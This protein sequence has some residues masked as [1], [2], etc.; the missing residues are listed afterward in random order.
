MSSSPTLTIR[1]PVPTS[2]AASVTIG[3][4][5]DPQSKVLQIAAVIARIA[6]STIATVAA[7]VFLPLPFAIVTTAAVFIA[8][9]ATCF[10]RCTSQHQRSEGAVQR[11]AS[12]ILTPAQ[13]QSPATSPIT[14]AIDVSAPSPQQPGASTFSLRQRHPVQQANAPQID[15]RH[16]AD[17]ARRTTNVDAISS[18]MPSITYPNSLD[19][20]PRQVGVLVDAAAPTPST[21]VSRLREVSLQID[22]AWQAPVPPPSPNTLLVPD[23]GLSDTRSP[24]A[25]GE[26]PIVIRAVFEGSAGFQTLTTGHGDLVEPPARAAATTARSSSGMRPRLQPKNFGRPSGSKAE[27]GDVSPDLA[28]TVATGLDEKDVSV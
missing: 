18:E 25:L 3:H 13:S 5:I 17:P 16:F 8:N 9:I 26:S 22:S 2:L 6:L 21:A 11:K 24:D 23:F 7:F 10:C 19:D 28:G 20:L 14:G 27:T 4:E 15:P 12:A 1:S